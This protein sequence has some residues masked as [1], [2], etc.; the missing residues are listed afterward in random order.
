MELPAEERRGAPP[1]AWRS[2]QV[3]GCDGRISPQRRSDARYCEAHSAGRNASKLPTPP[4]GQKYEDTREIHQQNQ[5]GFSALIAP[6]DFPIN[7]IGGYRF[8]L[9]KKLTESP[10]LIPEVLSEDMLLRKRV[11]A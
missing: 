7:I 2:C 10:P 5:L 6:S 1:T 3:P 4:T 9:A 11:D 8:P